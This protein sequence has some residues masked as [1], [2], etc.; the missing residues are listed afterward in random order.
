MSVDKHEAFRDDEPE[1]QADCKE[2]GR[3]YST[4]FTEHTDT[5]DYRSITYQDADE[6]YC[7]F[8]LGEETCWGKLT[9]IDGQLDQ[10]GKTKT[11]RILCKKEATV[12]D[13]E[14]DEHYCDT[15]WIYMC[16]GEVDEYEEF[17]IRREA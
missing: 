5:Y 7:D 4:T 14:G 11:E 13:T 3:P 2:C 10:Y 17:V 6:E 12:L 16:D 1:I 8:C 15:C 9:Y